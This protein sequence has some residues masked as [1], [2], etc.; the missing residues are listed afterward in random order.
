MRDTI[1]S[2]IKIVGVLSTTYIVVICALIYAIIFKAVSE[3]A[4]QSGIGEFLEF[5][6]NNYWILIVSTFFSLLYYGYSIIHERNEKRRQQQKK[7]SGSL[8]GKP[9]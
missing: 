5:S 8:I 3:T 6:I 4:T 7:Y 9:L 2:L 1:I